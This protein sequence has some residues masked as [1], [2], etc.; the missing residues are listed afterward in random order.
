MYTIKQL[1]E[2]LQGYDPDR[3]VVLSIDP[4]G[5]GYNALY[6][7]EPYAWDATHGEIGLEFLTDEL[8]EQG[9]NEND[10]KDGQPCVVLWP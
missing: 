2:E 6:N 3:V 5:N 4:E 1:I 10:V 7:I 9:Y 8:R